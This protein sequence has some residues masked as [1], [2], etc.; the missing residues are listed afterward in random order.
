VSLVRDVNCLDTNLV[1]SFILFVP[2]IHSRPRPRDVDHGA[3]KARPSILRLLRIFLP[4]DPART[5][6]CFQDLPTAHGGHHASSVTNNDAGK[7]R[8]VAEEGRR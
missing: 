7:H 6:L 5:M 2:S 8:G 4:F 3:P 1:V